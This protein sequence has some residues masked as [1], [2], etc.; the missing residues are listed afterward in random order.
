M[1]FELSAYSDKV[2]PHFRSKSQIIRILSER[3]FME[4]MYCPAC[5]ENSI[6]EYPANNPVIDFFCESCKQDYQLKGKKNSMGHKIL[7]GEFF[8]MMRAVR[9]MRLPNFVFFIYN[10]T[11]MSVED[12]FFVPKSFFSSSIIE[13]RKALS[14]TARR[15]GW[16]GCNIL[17][18]NIPESAKIFAVKNQ[19]MLDKREVYD[20]W[21][22][23]R[24]M[25]DVKDS[26]A[27][28][29]TSDVLKCVD[30][31]GNNIFKLEDCY[32]FE[33]RLSNLHPENRNIKPKIRQ[34]L[35]I[36]RNKG[37]IEFLGNGIYQ[38]R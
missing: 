17:F 29:W 34:Q 1:Q 38:K 18:D 26:Q 25:A 32:N 27:R 9:E 10:P 23:I 31:I 12:L 3:W 4:N 13:R 5:S 22:K 24:F 33:D 28:G 16:T 8:T 19:E 15:A 21:N 37:L 11:K 20:S 36:L 7:D 6:R 2:P 14:P 30:D 35:Q